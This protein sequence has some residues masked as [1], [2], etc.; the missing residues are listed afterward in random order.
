MGYTLDAGYTLGA[1]R[2]YLGQRWALMKKF[3]QNY[4]P[5]TPYDTCKE[6]LY[7]GTQLK[8]KIVYSE[9]GV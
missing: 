2:V 7:V 4:C 5:I 3:S 6:V 9:S 8:Y 1:I